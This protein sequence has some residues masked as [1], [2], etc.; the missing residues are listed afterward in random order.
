MTFVVQRT[1]RGRENRAVGQPAGREND[2][3]SG[4]APP[5][6]PI[7]TSE[8]GTAVSCTI[9]WATNVA[10]GTATAHGLAIGNIVRIEGATETYF[11]GDFRVD[12]VADANTFTYAVYGDGLASS[13]SGTITCR[14]VV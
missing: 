9:A 7:I 1:I 3:S 11:N 12:T 4:V 6:Q 10:T 8:L 5:L 14:K 13:A 2:M